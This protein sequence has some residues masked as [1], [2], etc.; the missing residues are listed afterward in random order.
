VLLRVS[1][2]RKKARQTVQL[3]NFGQQ[4]VYRFWQAFTACS[5]SA[6]LAC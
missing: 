3:T 2:Q 4:S 5:L 1:A 6:D